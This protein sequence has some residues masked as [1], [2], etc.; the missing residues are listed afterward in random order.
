M[1]TAARALAYPLLAALALAPAACEDVP[2]LPDHLNNDEP[3]GRIEGT[4][5]YEGPR[6]RLDPATNRPTGRVVLLLFR[7]D[8][9]PPPQGLATSAEGVHIV[10]ASD[11]FAGIT[12]LPRNRVRA[13]TGFVF[14]SIASGGLYQIRA[15]YDPDE[16]TAAAT[17]E[18][19]RPAT[20]FHPLFAV[21]NQ[22]TQGDVA[23]GAVDALTALGSPRYTAI[24]VGT[25][26]EQGG[27]ARYVIPERGAVTRGVTVV[28]QSEPLPE[29][30]VFHHVAGTSARFREVAPEPPPPDRAR[31]PAHARAT[32]FLSPGARIL[33]VENNVVIASETVGPEGPPAFALRAGLAS[34]DERAAAL[35]AGVELREGADL[36]FLERPFDFD[37]D[38]V[39]AWDPLRAERALNADAHPTLFSTRVPSR[40]L[41]WIFPLVVLAKLHDPTPEEAAALADPGTPPETLARIVA[42]LNRAETGYVDRSNPGTPRPVY[43]TVAFGLVVPGGDPVTGL[44]M[45]TP[46]WNSPLAVN[47]EEVVQVIVSPIALEIRGPRI[48]DRVAVLPPVPPP[49]LMMLGE[50]L[51]GALPPC[52]R[53]DAGEVPTGLPPGRYAINLIAPTGQAWSVPNELSPLALARQPWDVAS[54]GVVVRVVQGASVPGMVCP[55][56]AG[57]CPR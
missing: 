26:V 16:R 25:R 40:R 47:R 5:V 44:F 30:P 35:R 42:G 12:V 37:N 39:L 29:R 32:G 48:E 34:N 21:R 46:P 18:G 24:P 36:R 49:F 9:P 19:E 4:I 14:P 38:G 51:S 17:P 10:S 6:P 33:E 13:T 50:S 7:A 57:Q 41:P 27:A 43:P 28:L 8:N 22:P 55:P 11:L 52:Y 23:G 56:P 2:D 54:Q 1:G 31:W 15:F 45:R 53:C 3:V 20:G